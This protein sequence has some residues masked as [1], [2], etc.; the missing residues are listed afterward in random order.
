MLIPAWTLS[1][2]KYRG[3][4]RPSS[5]GGCQWDCWGCWSAGTQLGPVSPTARFRVHYN[6]PGSQ[7][8][9]PQIGLV[10]SKRIFFPGILKTNSSRTRGSPCAAPGRLQIWLQCLGCER[11][12]AQFSFSEGGQGQLLLKE[13]ESLS[14][15]SVRIKSNPWKGS[16]MKVSE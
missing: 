13:K 5:N 12:S 15:T 10:Y 14:L 4:M 8:K 2:M 9:S 3:G 6:F 7:W 16:K 11:C 1:L